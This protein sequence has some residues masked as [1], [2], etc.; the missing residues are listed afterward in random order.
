M[1]T[2]SRAEAAFTLCWVHK[3]H[4]EGRFEGFTSAYGCG[5]LVWFERFTSASLAIAREKQ[6]KRWRREKKVWLIEQENPTWEDLSLVWD[7][8]VE[9]YRSAD[10]VAG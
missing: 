8:P 5:R 2:W 9:R 6:I 4:R 3:Q 7:G 10:D 1:S